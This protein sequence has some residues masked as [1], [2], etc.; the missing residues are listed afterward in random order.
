VD[1]PGF[2]CGRLVEALPALSPDL[3]STLVTDIDATLAAHGDAAADVRGAGGDALKQDSDAWVLEAADR[4]G[5]VLS[6]EEAIRAR[7]ALC[8]PVVGRVDMFPGAAEL[9]RTIRAAGARVV[10]LSNT[11]TRDRDLYWNDFKGYG[12]EQHIDAILTSIDVGFR[13]PH[14]AIFAAAVE[15]AQC[16]PEACLMV[17]NSEANDVVPA[18]NLGMRTVRVCIEEPPPTKSAANA[19]V[20]SLR[21]VEQLFRAWSV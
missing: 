10:I 14:P 8:M 15:A 7:R 9:L 19:V 6:A 1:R 13:K 18:K 21:E 2:V 11:I 3:A 16:A 17:G 20:T 12:V 4:C 5:I